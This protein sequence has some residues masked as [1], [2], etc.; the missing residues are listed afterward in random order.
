MAIPLITAGLGASQVLFIEKSR[1]G[2]DVSQ[3]EQLFYYDVQGVKAE[4][5]TLPAGAQVRTAPH[6]TT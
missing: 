3:S 2:T 6:L 1:V 4:R 5:A